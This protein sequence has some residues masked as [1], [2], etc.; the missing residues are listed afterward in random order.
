[1]KKWVAIIFVLILVLTVLIYRLATRVSRAEKLALKTMDAIRN[2]EGLMEG[3][4]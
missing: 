4:K 3:L 2:N 1:M